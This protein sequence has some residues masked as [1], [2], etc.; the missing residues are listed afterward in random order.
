MTREDGTLLAA[1]EAE[2]GAA[3]ASEELQFHEE[4]PEKA[5]AGADLDPVLAGILYRSIS[6]WIEL[7]AP[8]L[9]AELT[10]LEA[11]HGGA[12]YSELLY[13]LA[14]LRFPGHQARSHWQQI[15]E[16]REDMERRLGSSVDVRVALVAYFV[17]VNRMLSSPK[18]I[19]LQ[20]FERTR[21]F[22][23]R[24]G[25]TGLPNHR[26]LTEALARE[27]LRSAR[28]NQPASLVMIDVDNLKEYND[29]YGHEAGNVVLAIIAQSLKEGL[30][31]EDVVGRYGREEF[32]MILPAT[33][34]AGAQLVA[35]RARR[36][37]E[38]R[39]IPHGGS[40]PLGRITVSL[41]IATCPGDSDV[42]AELV[43]C[44]DRALYAAKGEGKN[45]V[46]IYGENRRSFHRIAASLRGG[47]R[48]PSRQEHPLRTVDISEAGIRFV[49]DRALPAGTLLELRLEIPGDPKA[50]GAAGRVVHSM[51]SADGRFE[52]AVRVA[53]IETE[54]RLALARHI[55]SLREEKEKAPAAPVQAPAPD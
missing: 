49:T 22:A 25:L 53:A 10:R 46:Q 14:H 39:D 15:V 30:R 21:Q 7:G 44:A 42:A 19:E 51:A 28:T 48:A 17:Q 33:S 26:Y 12:V 40:Q 16:L 47:Y 8:E 37:V 31:E 5:C 43:R 2:H 38:A 18:I 35:E 32:V 55:A 45:R 29:L 50:I 24:D 52:V 6:G 36:G 20:L 34:K 3:T 54:D 9:D 23:Y 41:G 4:D 11:T 1:R 27:V 13:L